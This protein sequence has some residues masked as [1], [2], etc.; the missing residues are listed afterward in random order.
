MVFFNDSKDIA[1]LTLFFHGYLFSARHLSCHGQIK[2][3]Y[4]Q[5]VCLWCLD[6]VSEMYVRNYGTAQWEI[7]NHISDNEK[8]VIIQKVCIKKNK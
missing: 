7:K 8:R 5:S 2:I 4:S 1:A 6:N 3:S